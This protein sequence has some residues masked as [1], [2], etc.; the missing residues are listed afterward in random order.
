M[1]TQQV[2]IDAG[3]TRIKCALFSNAQLVQKETFDLS[4]WQHALTW[5]KNQSPAQAIISTVGNQS[6]QYEMDVKQFAQTFL[7]DSTLPIPF[8]NKYATPHTLGMDRVAAIA[9]AVSL[10]PN[11]P[12][13]IIDIG[14]C[15]TYDFVTREKEYLGGAISPGLAMRLKAMHTFTQKLPD[16]PFEMPQTIMGNSTHTCMQAGAYFG[17]EAEIAYMASQYSQNHGDVKVILCGGDAL[18]FDKHSKTNI[19]AVPDLVLFGLYKILQH[20]V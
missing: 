14:T 17:V 11:T 5:V 7:L 10:Y 4:E 16:I 13:L 1:D 6:A 19:F 20:N 3:N 15:I 9:G 12:C 2:V 8:V 18:L